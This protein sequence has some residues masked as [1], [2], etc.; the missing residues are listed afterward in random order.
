MRHWSLSHLHEVRR[1]SFPER[2]YYYSVQRLTPFSTQDAAWEK[3]SYATAEL[4]R[5]YPLIQ[6]GR[7]TMATEE[8]EILEEEEA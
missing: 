2:N 7:I 5:N 3:L 6:Q 8:L 4:Y 1:I